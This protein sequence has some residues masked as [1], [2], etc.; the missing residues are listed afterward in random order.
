[1]DTF[2]KRLIIATSSTLAVFCSQ[3]VSSQIIP[4]SSLGNESSVVRT[5][6]SEMTIEGGAIRGENLFHS[7][8]A[9]DVSAGQ[10]VNFI[11]FGELTHIFSRVTGGRGS[12]ILGSLGIVGSNANLIF[13]NS[14]GIDFG[15]E[16]RLELSGSF[17][18]TTAD[19]IEFLDGTSFSGTNSSDILTSS[20]PTGLSLNRDSA[21]TVQNAGHSYSVN[22]FA[23]LQEF[24]PQPGLSTSQ[25]TIALI[26]GEVGF[27]G[28]ILRVPDGQIEIAGV[29]DGIVDIDL[30][31][32]PPLWEFNYSD[33]AEFGDIELSALSVI[34]TDGF[35]G[36][37]ILA[38]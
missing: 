27:S 29:Q 34:E 18:A 12:S 36:G 3:E 30:A 37:Q 32:S 38:D 35:T 24:S 20:V 1:M 10:R 31:S 14:N 26:A 16:A 22:A 23:P 4:D 19:S 15:A 33:V 7:F 6:R 11:G 8:E 17:L 28:G 5:S 25:Q 21:I 9:F 13:L 2:L